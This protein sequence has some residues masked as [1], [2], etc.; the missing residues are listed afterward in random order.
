M[1]VLASNRKIRAFKNSTRK[2]TV[3]QLFDA[4]RTLGDQLPEALGTPSYINRREQFINVLDELHKRIK[5]GASDA[6]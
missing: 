5:K 6:S 3:Q 1:T 4:L 2:A